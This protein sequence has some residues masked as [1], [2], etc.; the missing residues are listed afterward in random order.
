MCQALC[1]PATPK[2]DHRIL[3]Y[4]TGTASYRPTEQ[5]TV[6]L[7]GVLVLPWKL[8]NLGYMVYLRYT[9]KVAFTFIKKMVVQLS[10]NDILQPSNRAGFICWT[11]GRLH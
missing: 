1:L 5:R 3:P 7:R 11:L 10:I 8:L 6:L 2:A 9:F 4:E